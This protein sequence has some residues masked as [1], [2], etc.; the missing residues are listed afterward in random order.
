MSA[1]Y[2]ISFGKA[3]ETK[4]LER[5]LYSLRGNGNW[6]GLVFV[7]TDQAKAYEHRLKELNL[8][9]T[10]ST[11][12]ILLQAKEEDLYPKNPA[13]GQPIEFKTDSM[14]YKRFKTLFFDYLEEP[15]KSS[16]GHVLYLDVEIVI[17]RPIQS[18][19]QDYF[20]QMI[21]RQVFLDAPHPV[22]VNSTLPF[23]T[24]FSDC[25]KCAR[26][27]FNLNGGAF[28]L[29]KGHDCLEEWRSLFALGATYATADQRYLVT[30]KASGTCRFYQLPD[31]HRI[32]P[33]RRDMRLKQSATVVHNTNTYQA[34]KIPLHL[35][36]GYFDYLLG[37][38]SYFHV[39][40][41]EAF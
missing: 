16:I 38:H 26:Q 30:M 7:I 32:Y 11:T 35:Q 33:T 41:I 17:A 25:P 27:N 13:S 36:Q 24:H 20:E 37:N 29:Y 6:K 19:F 10:S 2:T 34:Q 9:D 14:R 18:L 1:I 15:Y 31:A 28:L 21:Q 4:L 40:E 8:W 22:T 3:T 39:D 23:M 5:L 12:T